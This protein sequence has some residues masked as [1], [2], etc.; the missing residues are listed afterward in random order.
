MT[1][2]MQLECMHRRSICLL[3]RVCGLL[4]GAIPY[5][6]GP[7]SLPRRRPVCGPDVYPATATA[8]SPAASSAAALTTHLRSLWTVPGRFPKESL[9][10]QAARTISPRSSRWGARSQSESRPG[11]IWP[12][13]F[14]QGARSVTGAATLMPSV[15][16]GAELPEAGRPGLDDAPSD[17]AERTAERLRVELEELGC[18]VDG[19]P[20]AGGED[21]FGLCDYCPVTDPVVS[22]VVVD[23]ESPLA[24]SLLNE[25]DT[26]GTGPKR[27]ATVAHRAGRCPAPEPGRPTAN[28]VTEVSFGVISS[29]ARSRSGRLTRARGWTADTHGLTLG[30]SRA[31]LTCRY[32]TG[33]HSYTGTPAS[34]A[35]EHSEPQA[36]ELP[37]FRHASAPA[38]S[39][40]RWRPITTRPSGWSQSNGQ[41][42]TRPPQ[43][44]QHRAARSSAPSGQAPV[45]ST[46]SGSHTS[47]SAVLIVRQS[48]QN[49]DPVT[50]TRIST[51]THVKKN[52]EASARAPGGV[53]PGS[54]AP[55]GS[56]AV[57]GSPARE[58]A[59]DLERPLFRRWSSS[60]LV[61]GQDGLRPLLVRDGRASSRADASL[62]TAGGGPVVLLLGRVALS[63]PEQR[64]G[65]SQDQRPVSWCPWPGPR[66]GSGRTGRRQECGRAL[67]VGAGPRR[68]A[69]AGA[70]TS[71]RRAS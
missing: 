42:S 61:A 25:A 28:L 53:R 51:T 21:A 43:C 26:A 67:P 33:S 3:Q 31:P 13:L 48:L 36:V 57:G 62:S 71:L 20:V 40:A 27:T 7:G 1:T 44:R 68:R 6:H 15:G 29:V 35:R 32:R 58:E 12:M 47:D 50:R 30:A 34:W 18:F 65:L 10:M 9:A 17:L 23:H 14:D 37:K 69:S 46:V 56:S 8:G 41:R 70:S 2:N 38:R 49:F 24:V 54:T 52:R 60:P 55:A 59:N 16:L 4:G 45:T 5:L 22:V 19:E 63:C 11:S 66:A 39:I 64:H